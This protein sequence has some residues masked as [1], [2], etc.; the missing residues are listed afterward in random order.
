L[1][2]RKITA[3]ALSHGKFGLDSKSSYG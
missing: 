2:V 3:S 1:R